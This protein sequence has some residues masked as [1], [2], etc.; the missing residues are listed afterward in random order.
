MLNAVGV[1]EGFFCKVVCP[2][3]L[4]LNRNAACSFLPCGPNPAELEYVGRS[5]GAWVESLRFN[6]YALGCMGLGLEGFM[7]RDVV[8]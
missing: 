6:V 4:G 1:E 3:A 5:F 7:C 8:F 2:G